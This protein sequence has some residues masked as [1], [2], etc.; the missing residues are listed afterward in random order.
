VLGGGGGRSLS[1]SSGN[2]VF[3]KLNLVSSQ[4]KDN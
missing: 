4:Y 2:W 3:P 1:A